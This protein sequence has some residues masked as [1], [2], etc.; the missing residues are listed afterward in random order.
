VEG[1]SL[2]LALDQAGFTLHRADLPGLE[3]STGSACASGLMEA[4]HVLRAIRVP[5][6]M[7]HG[8]VRFSLGHYNTEADVDAALQVIPP[9]IERLR[10][11]SPLWEDKQKEIAKKH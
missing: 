7:I 2:V 4:S 5:P 10:N 6:H 9:I 1:E 8:S 3:V 11:M